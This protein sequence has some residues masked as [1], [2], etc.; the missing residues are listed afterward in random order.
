MRAAKHLAGERAGMQSGAYGDIISAASLA[1]ERP[2]PPASSEHRYRSG[3]RDNPPLQKPTH[4][5]RAALWAREGSYLEGGVE[6]V[7]SKV[8]GFIAC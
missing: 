5:L 2:V 4:V 6:L 7:A 3:P 1:G 8:A